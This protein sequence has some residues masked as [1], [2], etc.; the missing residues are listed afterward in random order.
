MKEICDQILLCINH[1]ISTVGLSTATPT[2]NNA[3]PTCRNATSE[4]IVEV[5]S[6]A[7]S[8]LPNYAPW[9]LLQ[10]RLN[11]SSTMLE[12][13]D[14]LCQDSFVERELKLLIELGVVKCHLGV[15]LCHLFC[16][17]PVD[18]IIT[19]RTEYT[20]YEKQVCP[21]V[22]CIFSV[23]YLL[24]CILFCSISIFLAPLKLGTNIF[25]W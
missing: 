14:C 19:A 16:P 6:L 2:C 18:P 7:K 13:F 1:A 3:T 23:C 8:L 9:N 5:C 25:W 4:Y 17:A 11:I 20:C 10:S 24:P 21:L 12:K 15:A 22:I